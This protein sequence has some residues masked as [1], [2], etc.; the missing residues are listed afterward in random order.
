MPESL[1]INFPRIHEPSVA[2]AILASIEF[3]LSKNDISLFNNACSITNSSGNPLYSRMKA[4]IG[5]L[6]LLA[7]CA[8]SKA[9]VLF[10][11]YLLSPARVFFV[12]RI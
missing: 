4:N 6:L 8:G 2:A 1:L 12:W 3:K 10:W 9:N 5:S 7:V 11:A